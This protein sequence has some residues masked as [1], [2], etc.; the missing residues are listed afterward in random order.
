MLSEL[1]KLVGSNGCQIV[2]ASGPTAVKTGYKAYAAIV[3]VDNTVI[4]SVTKI[5]TDTGASGVV[6]GESWMNA[7]LLAGI[8][9]VPFEDPITSIT[10]ASSTNSVMLLLDKLNNAGV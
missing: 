8:D 1:G 7:N 4:T 9:F 2:T 5:E 3:R 6:T 10:L